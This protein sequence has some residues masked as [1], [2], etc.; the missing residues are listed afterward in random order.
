MSFDQ[1]RAGARAP[2]RRRGPGLHRAHPRPGAGHPPRPRRPR[3]AR[4]RPDRHRQDGRLRA[5]DAPAPQRRQPA[6]PAVRRAD[7]RP[8]PRP[9]PRARA[10][11]R[12]E[13]PRPTAP[14]RPIRSTAIYGGVGFDP[15]VRALRAGAEIVV[16][17]PGRLLDHVGQRTIDL[18]RVEVL[19]LDEADR[20]LDMGFI[21]DIRKILALLPPR[22]QNLLFSPPSPTRSGASPAASCDD[23]AFGPGHAAQHRRRA[24][25][26]RSSIRSTASASASCSATSSGP[27]RIDQALVFTRTKHGANRL[28]EQ[29]ERDGIAAAAIH[30]NKSQPPARPRARRLQGRPRRRSS[31]RPRSPRAASTSTRCRT[32]STSSCRWSPRTTSTASAAPAG[33]ASTAMPSRSSA[34]TRCKLLRDIER[35]LGRAIPREVDRRAS[36]PTARSAPSRSCGAGSAA[37]GRH[38]R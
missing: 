11:G 9:H 20:M 26:R 34:S 12:G 28:A 21:R 35:V 25:R 32:S 31:S 6:D 37:R 7:P 10:P 16:A 13:R 22:R 4:R 14:Q 5:A 19:V 36:S 30:G 24:R 38:A 18:S 29:L 27:A 23:P 17:T 1:P 2:P 8:R 33:R 3:P 15:Q